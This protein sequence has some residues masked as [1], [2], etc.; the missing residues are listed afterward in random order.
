[1]TN[2]PTFPMCQGTLI[3]FATHLHPSH[4]HKNINAHI[5]AIKFI[6][7]ILGYAS[8][9]SNYNRLYRVIRGIKRLQGA[10]FRR[11]PRIPIT[12]ALLTQ[13]GR[14]LWNSTYTLH[15]KHMLWAVMLTAFHGFLRVSEYTSSHVHK[16]DPTT[17]LCF[18]DITIKPPAS[19]TLYIKASKTDPFR[20]GASI[21]LFHNNSLLSPVQALAAYICIHPLRKGPL[22]T[23][24]DGRY[25]TRASFTTALARIKPQQIPTMSSHSFR[26][27]AATTAAAAGHPRWLIQTLGRWSS[28]CYRQYIRVPQITLEQVSLSLSRNHNIP[29]TPFDPD[30]L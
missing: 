9:T 16:Y 1:M 18:Q 14:N 29:A 8:D 21:H 25:L 3:L 12:P 4:S 10:Q 30:N 7:D 5:A 13:L 20:Q 24:N 2:I 22:F 15:D 11:P 19:I 6:A 28:N 27:G 26:I 17:T 23:W